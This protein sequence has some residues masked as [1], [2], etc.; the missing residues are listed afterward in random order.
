MEEVWR[1]HPDNPKKRWIPHFIAPQNY[2]GHQIY[3][4]G[5]PLATGDFDQDGD[6]DI[7]GVL[8]WHQNIDGK[9]QRW[10]Y[11]KNNLFCGFTI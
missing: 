11:K 5:G 2:A 3:A 8:G 1:Y 10:E 4:N 7:A 6:L 9:G